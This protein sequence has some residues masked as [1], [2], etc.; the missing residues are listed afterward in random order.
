[1]RFT[2][3]L[4]H[5]AQKNTIRDQLLARAATTHTE[6]SRAKADKLARKIKA[7]TWDPELTNLRTY[8]DPTGELATARA[9]RAL[10]TV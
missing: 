3:P 8:Q 1:M 4:D 9:D 2:L 7:G 6:L 5:H 10:A